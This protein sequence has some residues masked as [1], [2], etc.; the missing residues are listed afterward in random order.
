VQSAVER[1]S[2]RAGSQVTVIGREKSKKAKES[3]FSQHRAAI[4]RVVAPPGADIRGGIAAKPP[5]SAL[6]QRLAKP[7]YLAT[8]AM[9]MAGWMWVLFKGL[10]WALGD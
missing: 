8:I 9:A 1:G 6:R 5:V 4:H 3:R 2:M 7:V 10:A